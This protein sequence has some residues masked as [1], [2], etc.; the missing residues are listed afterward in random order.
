MNAYVE[1]AMDS[2]E[3]ARTRQWISQGHKIEKSIVFLIYQHEQEFEILKT[4]PFIVAQKNEIP[5]KNVIHYPLHMLLDL[6]Y[7]NVL[8]EVS[9][10]YSWE[11][12]IYSFLVMS[13][14]GFGTD[15]W[16]LG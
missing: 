15:I 9:H 4:L 5:Y 2:S 11:I 12:L 10:L 1:N 13:L 16:L 6:I 14:C 3:K 7:W 8:R